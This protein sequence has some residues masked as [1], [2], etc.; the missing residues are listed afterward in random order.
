M[1]MHRQTG[2]RIDVLNHIGQC[3]QNVMQ[4]PLGT[5]PMQL[6]YGTDLIDIVDVP[7][8]ADGRARIVS[9]TAE[10]VTT[11]ETRPA[12]ERVTV[13]AGSD[14]SAEVTLQWAYEGSDQTT[15]VEQ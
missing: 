4:T 6:D 2:Q 10:A 14:G 1:P 12:V 8:N 13:A 5:R 11:W 9:T 15:T 7:L 3:V